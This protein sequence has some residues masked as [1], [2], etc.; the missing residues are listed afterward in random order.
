MRSTDIAFNCEVMRSAV[1]MQNYYTLRGVL[2]SC[3]LRCQAR[4]FAPRLMAS[5]L[6]FDVAKTMGTAW[7]VYLFAPII[8]A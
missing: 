3:V 5:L 8:G 7:A 1:I 2:T 6:G 4:E